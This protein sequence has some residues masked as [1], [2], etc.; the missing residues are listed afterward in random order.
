MDDQPLLRMEHISKR[1]PGVQA[2]DDV[3]FEVRPGEILG[4]LGENG[5]GKS[6]L[7]KILSGVYSKDQGRIWFKG[8]PVDIHSP[9]EA[10]DV[11]ITTIYQELALVPYLSVAENI[12]L[13]RE[14][15]RV[16][17]I[18]LVD[19]KTQKKLAEAIMADLGVEIPGDRLVKDLTVA[20]QQMVE[21][22]RAVSRN[23]S[24]ILM[25]EP[26]SAL[27][28]KEVDA[29]FNLMRRLKEKGVSVVFISHRLEE[30]L[31]VVDRI[32]IMRDGQR[33]GTMTREEA[34]ETKI[35]RMMVG[36]EVG[37][38]PKEEAPVGELV[39]EVRNLSGVNGV[40]DVSFNIRQGEI[41]GL[42]GLV[43]AGR[44]EVA[45]LIT[46][47][48]HITRGDILIEGKPAKIK[49]TADAVKAG[50]GWVPEDRK[51]HGLVLMM[52]VKSN[53][54]LAILKR[55]SGLLGAVNAK[56]ER[57]I[58]EEYVRALSIATPGISQTVSNL[59]GGNQQKVVVAKWLSAKPK[60]L[61]MDE[62]T[63]G[64]D[65]GAKAEVHAL[66]SRLAKEGMAILMIS[67]EMPEIIGMSD[68]VIVMCQGRVTG[69]FARPNL[70]QEEIMTCA[71]RFLRL[72]AFDETG[73]KVAP[74]DAGDTGVEMGPKLA[75]E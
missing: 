47:A 23:A 57:D 5:A 71:T 19:F 69:E 33:V 21:I 25:D 59:S 55:I 58:A 28:S 66:M 48:D 6:T 63:R 37:L 27:S 14:P 65:V 61:I 1:F 52:D 54:S 72:D 70:S 50:I 67:S 43:G 56:S 29:L 73:A 20:A 74:T 68:R 53:I 44:T 17:Q 64:I 75:N 32:V 62:P 49:N 40:R 30:V 45:R 12:F 60:L 22:A 7:V 41:V 34:T 36:R 46:G 13:N 42:A 51:Q 24:L 31:A 16:R 39:L 15:R 8:Q 35:I 2:L 4:F 18:G 9:H 38:F 3:D 10:Q 11:G 26:T